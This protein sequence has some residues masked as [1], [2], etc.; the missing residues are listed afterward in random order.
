MKTRV[1]KFLK[2]FTRV[3]L[4]LIKALDLDFEFQLQTRL[5]YRVQTGASLTKELKIKKHR[6]G[7]INSIK[8]F[9]F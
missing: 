2:I 8:N 1:T 5:E 9:N 7:K 3:R 4:R 6:K